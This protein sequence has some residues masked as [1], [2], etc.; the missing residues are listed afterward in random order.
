MN[1]WMNKWM[2]GRLQRVLSKIQQFHQDPSLSLFTFILDL[3]SSYCPKHHFPSCI[4]L[5]PKNYQLWGNWFNN[6]ILTQ[7]QL[8]G[9][10]PFLHIGLLPGNKLSAKFLRDPGLPNMS[11]HKFSLGHPQY[12]SHSF[13][14]PTMR[15]WDRQ[16]EIC[17]HLT[18]AEALK[19]SEVLLVTNITQLLLKL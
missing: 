13:Q 17:W 12:T 6:E 19:C 14:S 1:P 18:N 3:V 2:N 16:N 11:E 9:L 10:G 7:S 8:A 5:F 4:G 15:S